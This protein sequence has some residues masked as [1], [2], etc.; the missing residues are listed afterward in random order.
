[1]RRIRSKTEGSFIEGLKIIFAIA[2]QPQVQFS[3]L[4]LTLISLG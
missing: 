2:I 4:I 1:M 3:A